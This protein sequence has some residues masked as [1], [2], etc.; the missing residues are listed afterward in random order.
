MTHVAC[1][2]IGMASFTK[3]FR[4]LMSQRTDLVVFTKDHLPCLQKV[5]QLQW[6][7][8]NQAIPE[9]QQMKLSL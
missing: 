1:G 5:L 8:R 6:D 2:S 3:P 7:R 9:Q 4:S